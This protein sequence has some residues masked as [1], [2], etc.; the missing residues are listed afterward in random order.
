MFSYQI[1]PAPP[2]P[3]PMQKPMPKPMLMQMPMQSG[4]SL[5]S[6][7]FENGAKLNA[8]LATEESSRKRERFLRAM[9]LHQVTRAE[10]EKVKARFHEEEDD[11][12]HHQD[13]DDDDDYQEEDN[14]VGE[15][16]TLREVSKRWPNGEVPYV[17][18][19]AFDDKFRVCKRRVM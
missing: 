7:S 5:S 4:S 13:D 19:E 1:V 17:L 16:S 3:I 9:L 15:R 11:D 8:K 12:D 6:K 2:I 14:D 18:E 10:Q